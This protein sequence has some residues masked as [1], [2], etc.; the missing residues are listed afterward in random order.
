MIKVNLLNDHAVPRRKRSFAKPT[1]S[2]T[3]LLLLAIFVAAIGGMGAWTWYVDRQIAEGG[4]RRD[5][6]RAREARLQQLRQDIVRFEKLKQTR[7]TRIAV[8]EE[9]KS[10]QTGPVLLLNTV[11]QSIPKDGALWLT[12][13]TQREGKVKIVGFTRSMD[14]IPDFM[15]N[16]TASGIF[17]S[18]DL[19]MVENEKEKESS[20]FSLVCLTPSQSKVEE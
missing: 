8:I 5:D 9:L 4:A 15:N 19:E 10:K 13:L 3:G 14:V 16:L 17:Q 2:P 6:L 20:K 7:Q 18:V 1:V 12:A 11:V